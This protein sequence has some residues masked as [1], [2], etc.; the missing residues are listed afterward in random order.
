[1]V[2]NIAS[3]EIEGKPQRLGNGCKSHQGLCKEDPRHLA[4]HCG[5]LGSGNKFVGTVARNG[6]C[7]SGPAPQADNPSRRQV[8]HRLVFERKLLG[9]L[10]ALQLEFDEVALFENG[11]VVLG[12]E[13]DA[14]VAL[15]LDLIECEVGLL[16]Q[17]GGMIT[18]LRAYDAASRR[19]MDPPGIS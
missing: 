1:M 7:S 13:L 16:V 10:I 17:L 2:A 14:A 12:E 15:A 6:C 19:R 8:D 9:K 18:T 11:L 3:R 5:A 4:D